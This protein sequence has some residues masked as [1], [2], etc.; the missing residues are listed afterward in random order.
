[1]PPPG[2]ADHADPLT[3]LD[4][5]IETVENLAPVW[6]PETHFLDLHAR[7]VTRQMRGFG[8][9]A[10]FVRHQQRGEGF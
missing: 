4:A 5:E 8:V 2:R 9:V 1:M 6:V 7:A 3:C 10:Q